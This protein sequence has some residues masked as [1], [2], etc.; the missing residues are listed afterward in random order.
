M[1]GFERKALGWKP[2]SASSQSPEVRGRCLRTNQDVT[3][4]LV[5]PAGPSRRVSMP[6]ASRSGRLQSQTLYP[7][8]PSLIRFLLCKSCRGKPRWTCAG[9]D[10]L[11][12]REFPN[13]SGPTPPVVN[14][15]L[16][17]V[18]CLPPIPRERD[19]VGGRRSSCYAI[20]QVHRKEP[21]SSNLSP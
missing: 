5:H 16:D 12:S 14:E 8:E 3:M 6:N 15:P 20:R 4:G 11:P 18:P 17:D 7:S 2:E 21:A 19:G 1:T 13:I 10:S 9:F